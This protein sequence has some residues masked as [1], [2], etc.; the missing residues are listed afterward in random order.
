VPVPSL[1]P[2][3]VAYL[4]VFGT[5]TVAC[6]AVLHRVARIEDADTRRGLRWLLLTSAG[7]AAA[8]VGYHAFPSVAI[9]SG[10]HVLGLVFGIATIGPWL[11]FCSAYTGRHLHRDP[12]IRGLAVAIFL[13][14]VPSR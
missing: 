4:V 7:W 14:I 8:H 10:F 5:A 9:A 13:G 12:R 3:V 1:T 6:L 2:Q 11:Y